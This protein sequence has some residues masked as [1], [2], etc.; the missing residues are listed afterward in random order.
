MTSQSIRNSV[1]LQRVSLITLIDYIQNHS[2]FIIFQHY[3]SAR[4]APRL[5]HLKNHPVFKAIYY[6]GDEKSQSVVEVDSVLID[7]FDS[8]FISTISIE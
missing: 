1:V 7:M 4:S 5:K 3:D 8:I 2:D 6:K